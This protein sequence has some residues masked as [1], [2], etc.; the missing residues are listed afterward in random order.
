MS[1]NVI[2][3]PFKRAERSVS[4]TIL[5]AANGMGLQETLVLG[6]TSDNEIYFATTTTEVANILH[7]LEKVK[8]E[9]L[10][11]DDGE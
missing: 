4:Q 7:L 9:I 2:E 5:D 6:W 11:A 10:K 3:G 8:F 1:D